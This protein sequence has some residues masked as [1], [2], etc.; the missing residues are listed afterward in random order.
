ME[1]KKWYLVILTAED[2]Y[3][4]YED[5]KVVKAKSAAQAEKKALAAHEYKG[6]WIR[7][8]EVFGPFDK[9]PKAQ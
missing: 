4:L 5:T 6:D 9:K 2:Y 7:A 1:K 3:T 8:E